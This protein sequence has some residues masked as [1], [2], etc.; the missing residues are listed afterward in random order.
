MSNFDLQSLFP[1]EFK[2]GFTTC[3]SIIHPSILQV[4]LGDQA[5]GVHRIQGSMPE[6][7]TLTKAGRQSWRAFYP[8]NS[9]NP[10]G[11]IKGGF[12]F[13]LSGPNGWEKK[14]QGA[15]EVSFGYRVIFQEGFQWVKGGKLPGT[16]KYRK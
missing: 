4:T 10:K 15:K 14:L 12:G 3:K 5:L 8:Q 1:V 2:E 6:R 16:C 11:K 9:I 7:K 13:Y